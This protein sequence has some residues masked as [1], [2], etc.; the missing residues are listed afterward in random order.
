MTTVAT[1]PSELWFVPK[2]DLQFL[3][4]P[5][6]DHKALLLRR[7]VAFL[8]RVSPPPNAAQLRYMKHRNRN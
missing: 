1:A 5:W 8:E 6:P 3:L 7:G 2:E 4:E